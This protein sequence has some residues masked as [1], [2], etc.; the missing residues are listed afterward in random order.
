VDVLDIPTTERHQLVDLTPRLHELAASRG[1]GLCNVFIRHTTAALT[2]AALPDGAAEDLLAV[3]PKL[4]PAFDF[5]HAPPE[6]VP[7]HVLSAVIGA[8]LTI[9]VQDGRL[10]LGAFQSVVLLEFQG[11]GQRQVEVRFFAAAT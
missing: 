10:G 6:H 8:S 9:P 5:Q 11:P 1:D 2:L 3:L 7:A 4:V